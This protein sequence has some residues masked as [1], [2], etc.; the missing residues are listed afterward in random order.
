LILTGF[1]SQVLVLGFALLLRKELG[2]AGM[3]YVAVTSLV[4][5]YA[6]YLSLGAMQAAEREIPIAIARGDEAEARSLELAGVSVAL[7]VSMVACA[8]LIA[9]G[10]LRSSTD[11]LLGAAIVCA[12]I[13]LLT[14]QISIWAVVR[15]RTRLRFTAL[16]WWTA[17]GAVA[18][19]LLAVV[20][21]SVGGAVGA[22]VGM[23][24]GAVL[25]G[26][27][28]A[29][30]ARVGGLALPPRRSFRRL[31]A[32]SP[33][34]LASGVIATLLMTVDQ[35]AV[36][37]TL[38]TT[39]LGLYS[40]AYLGNGFALK[41]PT[42]IGTVVYP[43]LQRELGATADAG[44]VFAMTSR[45]TGVLV[46]AMPVLVA[47][48]SVALPALVFLALPQFREAIG[49]M[50]LL[51]VGVAGIAFGMPAAHFLITVN[52]QWRQVAISGSILAIMAGAYFVA[53]AGGMMSLQVAAGV[54][55]AAYLASGIVMQVA[56]YRVAGQPAGPLV[57]LMPIYLIPT[58]ELL[59]GAVVVDTLV[60]RLDATGVVLNAAL[61]AGLF[62]VTWAALAWLHLRAHPES[63]G[64]ILM[65]IELIRRVAW[66]IRA[67]ARRFNTHASDDSGPHA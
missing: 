42:L 25:Q 5:S 9:I 49:P 26:A 35:L 29:R 38:G 59:G 23:V 19:S 33:A 67:T 16:G 2:P 15:L 36:G 58:I 1:L 27:L 48:F 4:T 50:R 7:A 61:Q 55:A 13:I 12:S 28:L 60:P 63:R 37:F 47:A 46:I 53:G 64:D 3:G 56:A 20:G 14:Q 65:L 17:A 8:A 18:G 54:D 32:L 40:A 6:S 11:P 41:V 22:L 34:F 39:S 24:I 43:R 10:A 66:R 62:G 52:R 44:R 21:A 57:R 30:V 45:T 31:A 51:L